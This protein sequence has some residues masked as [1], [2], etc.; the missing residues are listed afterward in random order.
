ME[1]KGLMV[2]PATNHPIV[3]LR[4][5][6][7]DRFL[8]IWIG[9]FEAGAIQMKLEG[10]SSERPMTHDLLRAVFGELG[11][12]VV[13]ITICD[14]RE[15]TFF[16]SIRVEQD[17]AVREIDARPSDALA[18]ALRAEVPVFVSEEVLER[19]RTSDQ[20]AADEAKLR[21]WFEGLDPDDMGKYTM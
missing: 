1:V 5:E 20:P 3:I 14:L 16:A 4:D 7:G 8:P 15:N 18:L 19:A 10:M 2:D 17:G 12:R 9:I 11:G 6:A 13:R 21:E